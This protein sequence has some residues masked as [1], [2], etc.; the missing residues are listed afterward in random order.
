MKNSK[1]LLFLT[2]ITCFIINAQDVNVAEMVR[3]RSERESKKAF[4]EIET[5]I[6]SLKGAL[7]AC[8]QNHPNKPEKCYEIEIALTKKSNDTNND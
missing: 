3:E 8:K 2:V 4:N 6:K 1:S 5:A 7:D